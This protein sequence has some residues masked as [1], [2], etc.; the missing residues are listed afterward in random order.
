MFMGNDEIKNTYVLTVIKFR[1]TRMYMLRA[2]LFIGLAFLAIM[3]PSLVNVL[4]YEATVTDIRIYDY[5]AFLLLGLLGG[6]IIS[7]IRY[8]H[9]SDYYNV[10]PQTGTSRFL[11]TQFILYLWLA[12]ISILA[13]VMYMVQFV[14][15]KLLS[16]LNSNIILAFRTDL[17]VVLTGVFIFFL[18]GLVMISLFSLM[19]TL[20]RKFNEIA[21]AIL[22]IIA[23]ILITSEEGIFKT[24]SKM[25]SFLT[26]EPKIGIFVLKGLFVWLLLSAA[27][28]L[29]NRYTIYYKTQRK[30]KNSIVTAVGIASLILIS[31]IRASIPVKGETFVSYN[32]FSNYGLND[33]EY[34]IWQDKTILLD[35]SD[36][37]VLSTITVTTNFDLSDNMMTPINEHIVPF[38]DTI[39]IR[40]R[41][42]IRIMND[43]NLSELTNPEFTARLEDNQLILDYSYI[44]NTKVIFLSPWFEMKQFK[45]YQNKGLFFKA[46]DFYTSSSNGTGHVEI[47]PR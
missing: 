41:L 33:D 46:S 35:V 17:G 25:F 40:Y 37:E 39:E 26:E 20:I 1:T 18:Y 36:Y 15:F 32:T 43:Y 31:I 5:S 30:Y 8:K 3:I 9:L 22:M 38:G 7:C 24:I 21:I 11:S 4:K 29:V 47:S 14:I 13:L 28:L 16:M 27:A 44:K 10:F 34:N 23:A 6:A 42:P 19:A 45:K 2:I 12:F